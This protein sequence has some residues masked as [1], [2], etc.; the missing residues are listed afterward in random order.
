MFLSKRISLLA[1]VKL[2]LN[3]LQEK[4]DDFKNISDNNIRISIR[5]AN[6]SRH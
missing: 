5:S 4:R 6:E 3:L 1:F 2:M